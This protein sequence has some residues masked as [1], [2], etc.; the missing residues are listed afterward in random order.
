MVGMMQ[1]VLAAIAKRPKKRFKTGKFKEKV[2]S[3]TREQELERQQELGR[4]TAM[5]REYL[6][7]RRH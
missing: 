2:E 7:N 1:R 6:M 4:Q 3:T 5:T